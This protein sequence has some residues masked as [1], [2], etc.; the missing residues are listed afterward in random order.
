MR[1]SLKEVENLP[2]PVGQIISMSVR[3]NGLWVGRMRV[4][5]GVVALIYESRP[6]VTVDAASLCVKS[7]NSVI[8]RGGSEAIRSN[9]ILATLFKEALKEAG[10]PPECL[11]FVDVV[12]REAVD[13][14]IKLD[15]IV[16]LIIPRGGRGL[17][18]YVKNNATVPSLYHGEGN[19]HVYIHKDADEEMAVSIVFNAK[20]QRPSVC[21][22]AEKLLVHKDVAE[23]LLPPICKA[24]MEAGVQ[25]RGCK[26][27]KQIIPSAK[28]AEEQDWSKEY[29]SLIIAV[30]VVED[31]DEAIEHIHRYGSGHTEAI[32]TQSYDAALRFLKEVD[33]A[34]VFVNCSTRFTDGG[35]FGLGAEI[36]ISTQKLHV[37]GPMGLEELCTTKFVAFGSGQIRR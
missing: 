19:C 3:P 28:E 10:L 11:G 18:D 37:R 4:P 15:G 1:K 33:S 26:K 17:I 7:G 2:D 34:A 22:A 29:L 21:N 32:V 14:L 30:R 13:E 5:I 36:G 23:K 31:M 6:N 27:T 35:E 12:E 16:D 9:T 24:L 25:I 20:V 8:L